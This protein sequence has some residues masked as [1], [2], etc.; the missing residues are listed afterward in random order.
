MWT[1][2]INSSVLLVA[3]RDKLCCTLLGM[4]GRLSRWLRAYRGTSF[5]RKRNPL[6]P[7][8]RPLP[9]VLGG[10]VEGGRFFVGGVTLSRA[11]SAASLSGR[12]LP[13]ELTDR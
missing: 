10:S 12:K 4:A 3:V 2:T 7:Y 6:R 1:T 13:R 11:L 5:I 9:R 8:R